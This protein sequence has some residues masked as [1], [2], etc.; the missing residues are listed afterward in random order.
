MKLKNIFETR[1]L[2]DA[3][4]LLA[5]IALGVIFSV[6]VA[7]KFEFDWK[8]SAVN[9]LTILLTFIITFHLGQVLTHRA[10]DDRVEK[11][12][13]ISQAQTVVSRLVKIADICRESAAGE[14]SI[15]QGKGVLGEFKGL[16]NDLGTLDMLLEFTPIALDLDRF[17]EIRKGCLALKRLVTG[18]EFPSAPLTTQTN[19]KI[20]AK[21][22]E[23]STKLTRLIFHINRL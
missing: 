17:R 3:T 1:T 4:T 15:D 8:V 20:Q 19:S 10:S 14:I 16:N 9:L 11:S 22:R 6:V 5:G 13:L 2:S 12:M 23:L 18:A 7:S 21:Q